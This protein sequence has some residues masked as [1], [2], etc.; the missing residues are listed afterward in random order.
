M[1]YILLTLLILLSSCGYTFRGSG[2][3]LPEDV[4]KVYIP[5]VKN[6]SP[7]PG[8]SSLI[9]EAL[10]DEFERYG[11]LYVVNS[12][13]EADAILLADI[14]NV[15]RATQ[16]STST[17]DT[18]LELSTSF[19]LS[20]NLKRV[21]GAMLWQS[22]RVSVTKSFGTESNVVVASSPEFASGSISS[23]DLSNLNARE[24]SRGQEQEA[25]EDLAEEVA[26]KIYSQ[27]VLPE[28]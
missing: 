20:A 17:T 24:I 16:S 3:I 7:E 18:A 8:L 28:F 22:P 26:R 19:T 6:N 25:F 2:S 5:L 1:K 27:A 14:V 15:K 21:T 13:A 4:Q 23:Q 10:R 9:T 11:T 12:E